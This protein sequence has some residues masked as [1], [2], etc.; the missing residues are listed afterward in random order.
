MKEQKKQTK[1]SEQEKSIIPEKYQHAASIAI[2]FLSLIIFFHDVVFEGKVY[3][4]SDM[5][6]S[7]SFK[8]LIDD[9]KQNGEYAFWNP[10]IFCGM[11]NYIY[12]IGG[13]RY[14]A[15]LDKVFSFIYDLF[16]VI[17]LHKDLGYVIGF[18]F[19]FGIGMYCLA[20]SKLHNKII[21]LCVALVTLYSTSIIGWIAAG[22]ITKI[23]TM[24]LFPY[25]IFL[26][27]KIRK[28]FKIWWLLFLIIVLN[29]FQRG[30]VQMVFYAYFA[31]GIY[32]L[33]FFSRA[34]LKKETIKNIT[35]TGG[36]FILAVIIAFGLGIDSYLLTMEYTPYSIRGSDPITQT[37]QQNQSQ[38]EQTTKSG[39]THGGLDYEYATNWSFSPGEALT[40]FIPSLYGFGGHTYQGVLT[41]NQA[42][43]LNTYFGQMPFTDA[44]QYMGVV[45]MVLA[46]IGF[47]KNRKEP[48]VQYLGIVIILALL[49]SFGRTFSFFYDLMFYYFPGFNKFRVPAMIL[50]LLNI[51]IPLLAGYGILSLLQEKNISPE[52]LK[53]WKY[54]LIGIFSL[55]AISFIAKDII[56]SIY[57]MFFSQQEVSKKLATM[58]GDRPQVLSELYNF[59]GNTV[60][61]DIAIGALFVGIVLGI[62]YLYNKRSVNI[63]LFSSILVF[64][65]VADLWRVAYKSMETQPAQQLQNVFI[66][67][68]YV[69]QIQKD[70]TQYRI[71]EFVNGQPQTNNTLAYWRVQNA[72]GYHAAKLRAYQDMAEVVGMGNPLLWGLMNVKYIFSNTQDSSQIFT[73]VYQ[74][75]ERI[76]YYNNAF[77]PRAF[78]VNRYEIAK[79]IDIL[80]KI[81]EMSFNPAEVAFLM[82][83]PQQKIDVPSSEAKVE[84]TKFGMN[85]IEMKVH[86]TGNNLL[87]LSE[88]Y[89]PKGWKAFL[90]GKEIPIYRTNYLF[91]GVIVPPGEHTLAMKMEPEKFYLG[92]SISLATNIIV[93]FGLVMVVI[94]NVKN[95]EKNNV[96]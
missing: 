87:F 24:A 5:I 94:V 81:R 67:P 4:A 16:N 23:T 14:F 49:L 38:N 88:V 59:I 27:D 35:I 86:A 58:Y 30:H 61:N 26:I 48:F 47:I 83:D 74:G 71:L 42:V 6:A 37:T 10:Y 18:Y 15:L 89:Y 78:F 95:R 12:G 7:I 68:D 96:Q 36:S 2:I 46:I 62:I 13:T 32:F 39:L 69:Q 44:P 54:V 55:S 53:K 31:I 93:L 90:D 34:L 43:H 82:E 64:V 65:T 92:K 8:T 77:L 33:F 3:Q 60:A 41:Q 70:T 76:V 40:F 72:Y 11:P 66:A 63:I 21:A 73:P 85:E 84:Y 50:V 79:G 1:K 17:F 57:G 91:R 52:K 29:F 25:V 45:I 28:E 75:K 80:N 19:T 22:H 9:A 51:F 20:F 56:K